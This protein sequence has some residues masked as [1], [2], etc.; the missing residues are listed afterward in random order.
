M[1]VLKDG[2]TDLILYGPCQRRAAHYGSLAFR[3]RKQGRSV[4]GGQAAG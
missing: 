1:M 3:Y 4:G 2:E